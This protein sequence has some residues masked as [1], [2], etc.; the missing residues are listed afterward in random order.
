MSTPIVFHLSLGSVR[1]M[2]LYHHSQGHKALF[3]LFIPSQRKA[4]IFILDT[5][6]SHFYI[7]FSLIQDFH[8]P[9]FGR[10]CIFSRLFL[11]QE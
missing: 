7:I 10:Y 8:L 4:S 5:V 3:G 6:R 11:G 2:Y 9:H 1:H